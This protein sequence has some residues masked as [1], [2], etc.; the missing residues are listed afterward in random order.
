MKRLLIQAC[1][2]GGPGNRSGNIPISGDR[3]IESYIDFLSAEH[4][5]LGGGPIATHYL[6]CVRGLYEQFRN[7]R[8]PHARYRSWVA[9]TTL[10]GWLQQ[11]Q[12][13]K[14]RPS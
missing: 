13:A 10:C 8:C 12:E 1:Y 11:L 3:W 4:E 7:S 14:E 5:R 9:I 2:A 6:K